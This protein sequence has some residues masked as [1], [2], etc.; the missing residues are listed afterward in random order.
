MRSGNEIT[1]P[2]L[3]IL[4]LA[5]IFWLPLPLGSNRAW[6]WSIMEIWSF[7]LA[8][9]LLVQAC[10]HRLSLPGSLATA[11][12]VLWLLALFLIWTGIQLIPLPC[13]VLQ[14]I[15]PH[16]A[17]L[18]AASNPTGFASIA[19]DPDLTA[20]S[21]LKGIAY[22]TIMLLMLILMDSHKKIRWFA[23]TTLAAG[24]FQAAY[25]SYMALSGVEYSFFI[26]KQ[27][28]LNSATGTFMNRNH[29]AGFLEMSLAVGIGLMISTL[30][31][32]RALGWRNRLRKLVETLISPKALIR[33]TLII[34]CIGL[35]LSK[36]RMGN[37]AFFASL[38][39][40]GILFLLISRHATRSTSIFLISLIVLDILL[41]GS[42]IGV[43]KVVQRLEETN[44]VTEH[45]DEV[46]RDTLT[47][48]AAQPFT[49]IGA[50]NYS[51]V[52]P[53][54]QQPDIRDH[55]YHAHNDYL[56]FTSESG[57]IGVLALAL[58]L[59]YCLFLTIRTMRQRRSP[60]MLG[61]AFA[62]FMGMLSIL[63]HST[64]DFNLQ[65]PANAV[66][67]LLLMSLAII[68]ASLQSPRRRHAHHSH[69]KIMRCVKRPFCT[70]TADPMRAEPCRNRPTFRNFLWCR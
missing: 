38:F 46:D 4:F 11:R 53:N 18:L 56:E 47:M 55:Y 1:H 5:L 69:E 49:G 13:S 40:S 29:L 25:G 34:I 64:V 26:E 3:T 8:I 54:Y 44:M 12:P 51:S 42:W 19:L 45:R 62:A 22:V 63:I 14:F 50:G 35:I 58:A 2:S 67:F 59:L 20:K 16:A 10:R 17:E 32:A 36:S 24:L 23:Y 39:I 28:H 68:S 57:L 60:L 30:S 66:M 9:A 41:V 21:L 65:I 27:R 33:L 52:F 6:A 31:N 15:A 70:H 43:G 37:S 61:M 48:I 7:L